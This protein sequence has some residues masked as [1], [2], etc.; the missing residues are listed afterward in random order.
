MDD[1]MWQAFVVELGEAGL[2]F[3]AG[4]TDSEVAKVEAQY[5][6]RFPPDLRAF[7]QAGLPCG[8]GFPDWRSADEA[9]LREWFD[10]PRKGILADVLEY[11][12]WL[13]EWGTRPA[14]D[15]ETERVVNELVQAAPRLIPIICSSWS[16]R[17]MPAEPHLP[18]NPVFAVRHTDIIWRGVDLRDYLIHEFMAR[19]DV[20]IWPIPASVRRIAFW[21]VERFQEGYRRRTKRCT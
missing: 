21:D 13:E 5:G 8:E 11:G 12:F 4:L 9:T 17:M 20:N 19:E 18:G 3:D 1:P 7:L 10:F 6:F 14:F 2:E 16:S 15:E